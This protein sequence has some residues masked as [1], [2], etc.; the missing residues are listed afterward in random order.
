MINSSSEGVSVESTSREI[1]SN[2]TFRGKKYAMLFVIFLVNRNSSS[3]GIGSILF[4]E[5]SFEGRGVS[6]FPSALWGA[7]MYEGPPH[8]GLRNTTSKHLAL[9]GRF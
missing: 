6:G 1:S 4:K 8:G 5:Y 7:S 3:P 9:G 2:L